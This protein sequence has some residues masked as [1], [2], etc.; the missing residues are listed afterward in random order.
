MFAQIWCGGITPIGEIFT[1]SATVWIESARA[2]RIGDVTR[3]CTLADPG[4]GLTIGGIVSGSGTVVIGGAPMPSLTALA[5]QG[6]MHLAG[7]AL[8]AAADALK[9]AFVRRAEVKAARE[10]AEALERKAAAEAAHEAA[11]QAAREAAEKLEREAAARAAAEAAAKQAEETL[12]RFEA[13][14]TVGGDDAY[15][16]AVKEDLKKV[17]STDVGRAK[18]NEIVDAGKP[19]H[20]E[21]LNTTYKEPCCVTQPGGYMQVVPDPHGSW[22][23]RT[24]PPETARQYGQNPLAG[25][26]VSI[27]GPGK[28]AGSVIYYQPGAFPNARSPLTTSDTILAH[29]MN[30]ASNGARGELNNQICKPSDTEANRAWNAEWQD[31]EEEATVKFENEYRA[32]HGYHPRKGY[33]PCP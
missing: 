1:G 4:I 6:A 2:S 33:G 9:G 17:A 12:Q 27:A 13:H 14:V 26:R 19:L 21:P 30:H 23:G 32:A 24:Y 22:E 18:M 16:A 3:H 11:H 25:Q 8:G 20:I 31:P 15:K 10:A 7:K 5:M 28:G 29:E